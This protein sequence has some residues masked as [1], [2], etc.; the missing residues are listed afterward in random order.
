V[1][2][3]VLFVALLAFGSAW[4]Q[5]LDTDFSPEGAEWAEGAEGAG[6]AEGAGGA[7]EV[8]ESAI[9]A[10]E[11]EPRFAPKS[12][13]G[14][15]S[16]PVWSAPDPFRDFSRFRFGAVRYRER[17]LDSR[18]NRVLLGGVDLTDNLSGYP[19]WNLIT[20]ARR[21]G[22]TGGA[23]NAP[24]GVAGA[25]FAA[26]IG[27][28]ESHS[29]APAGDDLYI[30]LRTGDRYSRIGGDVRFGGEHARGGW[31]WSIA[32]TG[33]WGDDGHFKGVYS[34]EGG[35][36]VAVEKQWKNGASLTVFAAGGV[37]ERGGRVAATRE[38]FDLAGDNF[39]NPVWGLQGGQG[40]QGGQDGKTRNS[41]TS[42]AKYLFAAA[43]FA[44]PL[45]EK[46]TLSTTIAVRK[47]RGGRTRMAWFEAHSPLPD[48]YRSMPSFFPD[49]EAA[50]IV[51]EAWRRGDLSVTQLDWNSFYYNNTLDPDGCAAWLVEEQVESARDI[52]SNATIS[53]RVNSTI[54]LAGGVGMRVDNSRFYKVVDDLLGAEW[55]PN[56]D[57]YVSYN[58]G[59]PY[60]APPD[61]NDLRNP[62]RRVRK[63]ERFGYDYALTRVMP[64]VFGSIGWSG[65]RYGLTAS[66]ELTHARLQ[67][68]GFYEKA[69]FP[70]SDSFGRSRA[71][72]FTTW[73]L[74]ASGWLDL[75]VGHSVSVSL[76][77]A[78]EAPTVN[79]LF[80]SPRQNNFTVG[81]TSVTGLYGA[82]GAW[83]FSNDWLD[84]RVGGFVNAT[85]GETWVRQYYDDLASRFSDMVVRGVD[86][87]GYGVEMGI[88]A[89]PTRWLTLS[90]GVS[91]G[92]YRFNS[93]P[94]ATLHDAATGQI[95]VSDIVCWMSGLSTGLPSRVAGWEVSLAD[96]NY[97]RFTISGE[98]MGGRTVDVNPLFHS[99]RVAGIN[100][101]PEIMRLFTDQ[102][103]L[104][105]AFTLGGS[106]SKGWVLGSSGGRDGGYLRVSAGVRN[107]L[108][109][110]MIHSAYEQMRIM[111]RGYGL[112]RTFEP[113]P[114]KYLYSYPRTWSVS[115]SYRL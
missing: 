32:A 5:T 67:R 39:Y 98:W 70:G 95:I 57:Q 12:D 85:T 100:A 102:E 68:R 1:K 81:G 41:R 23:Y 114:P 76:L 103:R 59:E 71:L 7:G 83:G 36:S 11:P 66:A 111:R 54:Q 89:R 47:N 53:H 80:M 45:T 31:L 24:W 50:D 16:T 93:E 91:A 51:T 101:A 72:S 25:G 63:G 21:S 29:L 79:S 28:T 52:H 69:L 105:D 94:A 27:R 30:I 49:G 61:E 17:G 9:Y 77:A 82:E 56:V 62:G 99:S 15:F 18:H 26:G 13:E 6:W 14:I 40:G 97:L 112:G 86:R 92:R 22:G 90:T 35:G 107:V 38:A 109:T 20:L 74:A 96:R 88:S 2:R 55:I 34:D 65:P 33:Q 104:P 73:S 42:R 3:F 78:T 60:T 84:V 64:S 10:P 58:N 44:T 113:A 48:Y 110:S 43:Q 87:L 106:L 75:G 108:G 8:G 37:S 19:D 115:L 46:T 4:G